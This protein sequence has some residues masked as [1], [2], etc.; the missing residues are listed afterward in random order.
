MLR[1]NLW[2]EK[3]LDNGALGALMDILHDAG[4]KLPMN[5]P[6]AIMIKFVSYSGSIGRAPS[7]ILGPLSQ[8]IFRS[9]DSR[10]P[11]LNSALLWHGRLRSTNHKGSLWIT[12]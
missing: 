4:K 2:T 12:L 6:T 10:V 1:T 11:E 9:K 8:G 7:Y 3:G 5:L